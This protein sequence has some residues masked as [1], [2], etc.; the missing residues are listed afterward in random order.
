MT[1]GRQLEL[2]RITTLDWEGSVKLDELVKPQ[3]SITDYLTQYSGITKEKLEGVSTTLQDIQERLL[4][5]LSPQTILVG[6]SL[7]S[8]LAAL[9]MTHPWIVDTSILYTHPRGHPFKS[10]LR[11]LAQK[12]LSRSIQTGST[13]HDSVEDALA[14]LYLVKMKCEKGPVFGTPEANG[15]SIFKRLGRSPRPNGTEG[16]QCEGAVVDWGFPERG[17][18]AAATNSS[19]CE[20]DDEVVAGIGRAVNGDSDG[21]SVKGGG[22]DFVWARMRELEAQRGWWTKSSYAENES[23]RQKACAGS[24]DNGGDH[25]TMENGELVGAALGKA[26]GKSISRIKDVYDSLPACTALIV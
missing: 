8:D 26:V 22:V 9:K 1:E 16:N 3:N 10:S 13:G 25:P 18:G 21:K 15:E 23:L 24:N 4:K 20:S 6:H 7:N 17:Y 14:A 19:G 12:Y 5:M 11:W 2:T